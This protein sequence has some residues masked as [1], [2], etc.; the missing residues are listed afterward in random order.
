MSKGREIVRTFIF[1]FL[2][3]LAINIFFSFIYYY[4]DCIIN[5]NTETINTL[6]IDLNN[7]IVRYP[8]NPS[9]NESLSPIDIFYFSTI[10]MLTIGYGDISPQTDLGKIIVIIHGFAGAMSMAY[11]TSVLIAIMIKRTNDILISKKLCVKFNESNKWMGKYVLG[12]RLGNKGGG[13]YDVSI[14]LEVLDSQNLCINHIDPIEQKYELFYDM[15]EFD[16]DMYKKRNIAK[17]VND[18]N[19][20]NQKYRFRF[21][22]KGMDIETNEAIVLRKYYECHDIVFIKQY[23]DLKRKKSNKI[24]WKKFDCYE[25]IDN[26]RI[27]FD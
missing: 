5:P 25:K 14:K 4:T 8:I 7:D 1:V 11:F 2:I 13:L 18:I 26:R 16:V 24:K 17:I 19:F 21:S 15:I 3:F 22:L 20:D 12:I 9:Q 27:K 10:T 23:S 6:E